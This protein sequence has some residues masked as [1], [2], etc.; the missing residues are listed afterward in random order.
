MSFLCSLFAHTAATPMM[1]KH[2]GSVEMQQMMDAYNQS[3]GF[4]QMASMG[5]ATMSPPQL[6]LHPPLSMHSPPMAPMQFGWQWPF[7]QAFPTP[8]ASWPTS[9]A[10]VTST[11]PATPTLP[12]ERKSPKAKRVKSRESLPVISAP[13]APAPAAEPVAPPPVKIVAPSVSV[14]PPQPFTFKRVPHYRKRKPS[15]DFLSHLRCG[16]FLSSVTCLCTH[17]TFLQINAF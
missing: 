14:A 7:P 8:P 13:R 16:T 10:V 4:Y 15:L 17:V 12:P 1:M 2:P 6:P 9:V 5:M 11:P 3:V